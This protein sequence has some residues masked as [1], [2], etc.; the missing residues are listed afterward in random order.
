MRVILADDAVLVREG[1]ARLLTEHD[2]E[3]VAQARTA[4]ELLEHVSALR[5]DVAVVDIRMPPTWPGRG[6]SPGQSRGP[7]RRVAQ[8]IVERVRWRSAPVAGPSLS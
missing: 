6:R 8:A 5:P 1:L 3:V 2:F 4:E 7:P